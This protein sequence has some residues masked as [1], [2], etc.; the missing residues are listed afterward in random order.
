MVNIGK[1][2]QAAGAAVLLALIAA[3]LIF[4][5]ILL[6]PSERVELLGDEDATD[7]DEVN[8]VP[9]RTLLLENPG[10]IDYLAQKEMEHPLPIV[11]VYTRTESKVV[12][13]K[14]LAV[15][16]R[17]VFTDDT[18]SFLFSIPDLENTENVL[19]IFDVV[20]R[21]G[22]LLISLNGE[23]IYN[24]EPRKGSVP[25]IAL[26]K[27][28][29]QAENVLVFSASSPGAAI[30]LTN[31]IRL[32]E[33]QVIADVTNIEAQTSRNVFLISDTE[34]KNLEGV[35]LKFKPD[36][37]LGEVGKLSTFV[38]GREVYNAIPDCG[39]GIVSVDLVP[40]TIL[41]G[42]NEV[43]FS[44]E[45]GAYLLVHALVES[46]LKELMFPTYYFELSHEDY[47][48]V[49][50]GEKRVKLAMSFVDIVSIKSGEFVF[51]SVKRGFDTKGKEVTLDLSDNIV[52]GNNALKIQPKNTIEVR[53]LRVEL[54]D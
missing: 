12:A 16:K 18:S 34:K 52:R 42:E 7:R 32:E 17:A 48:A 2:G 33:I 46:Q 13:E 26:T 44:T 31:E 50:A 35:R 14:N 29:L 43:V 30:W 1:R 39:A 22:R 5:V 10:R 25:P 53:E 6:P 40:D 3:L 11:N 24:S 9:E 23:E 37:R 36:C 47:E 20:E 21:S 38:N 41:V 8:G 54:L 51:N 19:L 49:K 28:S 27:N 4:F 15:I 45:R